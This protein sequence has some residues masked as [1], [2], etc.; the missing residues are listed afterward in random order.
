MALFGC[1]LD[2]A[3]P[4]MQVLKEATT[5]LSGFVS[6]SVHMQPTGVKV[7]K[8]CGTVPGYI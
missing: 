1:V 4:F 3:S 8:G 6:F 2:S 7:R 5:R